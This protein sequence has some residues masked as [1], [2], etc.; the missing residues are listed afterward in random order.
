VGIRATLSWFRYFAQPV[1]YLGVTMLAAIVAATAYLLIQDHRSAEEQARQH[2]ENLAYVFEESVARAIRSADDMALQIRRS[3]ERD[4]AGTDLVAWVTDP[5]LQKDLKFQF[6]IAGPDGIV[7]ASSYSP[8]T[9]GISLVGRKHFQ[10]HVDDPDDEL[11]ISDPLVAKSSGQSAIFL[12]RRLSAADGSF[13]GIISV[14]VD[15]IQLEKFFRPLQLGPDG[16]VTLFNRNG[17]MLASGA[18]GAVRPDLT[19]QFYPNAPVLRLAAT[20]DRGTYWNGGSSLDDV[21]RLVSFRQVEGLPL[22]A[23]VAI[24]KSEIFRH[25]MQN[26]KV[27]FGIDLA[28]T[29]LIA[30]GIVFGAVREQTL[31]A[32][33]TKIAHQA[34]HDGLTALPNRLLLRQDIDRAMASAQR[35]GS[36]FNVL[37]FDLDHFKAVNDTLGHATGD[38][39]VQAVAQRL[40]A[41]VDQPDL[42]ARIG[43]DE[44]AVVQ[45]VCRDQRDSAVS[46]AARMLVAIG[47]PFNLDGH[48]VI[49]EATIGI[50]LYPDDG[51]EAGQLLKNADLALYRAKAD[52][53][54]TF[55]FFEAAMESE[56]RGRYTIEVDL[57]NALIDREFD[58]FYQPLVDAE[59]QEVVGCEALLRWT[60]RERG[61]VAPDTFIPIA[62]STGLIVP[63]G[64]WVLNRACKDAAAW[65]PRTKVAVNL[66]PIQF[67]K[68]DIVETVSAAL[69][70]SGLPPERLELEITETVLLQKDETNLSKLHQLK[71]LGVSIV[72][73]DFGTGYS[74]LSYLRTFPFDKVK[75]D[76][77]FVAEISTHAN[78]AAIVCAITGL[79]RSLD[80]TTTAEGVE[81]TDQLA[82]LRAAGCNE[83][84]GYL[85]GKP[86]RISEF[87]W[88][89]GEE[90]PAKIAAA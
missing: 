75:I 35:Q 54:N 48:Q 5:M 56:A 11:Y 68:G 28:T 3:Y 59:T 18:N 6:S 16:V 17:Y 45:T 74:S 43:G 79:A 64:A 27:Y 1:T 80:M 60:H 39:L 44:F 78:S 84:Q 87:R 89:R 58:V 21:E 26:A 70:E 33:V 34:H 30:I 20:A 71:M 42:V 90:P 4:P 9:V 10:V 2:A 41:C 55:R 72:L 38:R 81:T 31:V 12:T 82:L 24:A 57:R 7:T 23:A 46:L 13:N 86:C 47:E 62:E 67:R 83:M 51:H 49:V 63:L 29:I 15:L 22:I 50:A 61:M 73:D 65:S 52:G 88:K 32:A 40:R 36:T 77:S 76:R 25:A 19:G 37:M 14:W 66:S 8:A 69:V 85:F 53:R